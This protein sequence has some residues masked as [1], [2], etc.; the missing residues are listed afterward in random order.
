[1]NARKKLNA[2][3]AVLVAASAGLMFNTWLAFAIT[4]VLIMAFNLQ[5]GNTR[6][7]LRIG[8]SVSVGSSTCPS[9][10]LHVKVLVDAKP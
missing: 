10:A 5:A 6:P 2:L 1:M 8:E 9:N 7:A 4:F 3:Y